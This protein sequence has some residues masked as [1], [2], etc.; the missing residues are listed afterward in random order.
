MLVCVLSWLFWL[1]FHLCMLRSQDNSSLGEHMFQRGWSCQNAKQSCNQ[2]MNHT[3]VVVWV[4]ELFIRI[5]LGHGWLHWCTLLELHLVTWQWIWTIWLVDCNL[6]VLIFSLMKEPRASS[7]V[8]RIDP[9]NLLVGCRKRWLNQ[10]LSVLALS[11]CFLSVFSA[12][13]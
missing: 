5:E 6:A 10:A 1:S 11:I 3:V 7:R 13:Y 8:E 2:W 4:N 12:V 9:L